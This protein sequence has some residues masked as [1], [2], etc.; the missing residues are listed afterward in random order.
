M[1][2]VTTVGGAVDETHLRGRAPR[3]RFPYVAGVVHV[4]HR[5]AL[6]ADRIRDRARTEGDAAGRV[7]RVRDRSA[8]WEGEYCRSLVVGTKEE[9]RHH[10]DFVD[11][12]C[13]ELE[14]DR[15]GGRSSGGGRGDLG[16]LGVVDVQVEVIVAGKPCDAD[17]D[18]AR[19]LDPEGGGHIDGQEEVVTP[20]VARV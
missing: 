13:R 10:A 11:A 5:F 14:E 3:P 12:G 6:R 1:E 19:I 18:A 17:G 15:F 20:H 8:W 2:R 9:E 4:D 16:P 7:R